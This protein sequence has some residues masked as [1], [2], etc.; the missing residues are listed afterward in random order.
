MLREGRSGYLVDLADFAVTAAKILKPCWQ[1]KVTY[2][3][4]ETESRLFYEEQA[5]WGSATRALL[6]LIEE[7]ILPSVVT[8]Q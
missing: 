7:R 3:Q 5:N 8:P 1:N 4:M 2:H 6:D